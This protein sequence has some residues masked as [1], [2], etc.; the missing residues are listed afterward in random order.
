MEDIK[1]K[2]N[3]RTY[4]RIPFFL[5][6]PIVAIAIALC[7]Y[8]YSLVVPVAVAVLAYAFI[9]AGM[10]V[11]FNRRIVNS[12]IDTAFKLDISQKAYL[13]KMP[14]PYGVINKEGRILWGND[15]FTLMCRETEDVRKYI[16][17]IFP[18][19]KKNALKNIEGDKLECRT[20]WKDKIFD[21]LIVPLNKTDLSDSDEVW[22]GMVMFDIT[23]LEEYKKRLDDDKL[24][25]AN[26]YVDNYEET[27]ESVEAVKQSLLR[28]VIERKI[29]KY[30]TDVDA[31]IRRL[32]KDKYFLVFPKRHLSKLKEDK[33]SI[34][35]D[36]RSTKVGNE[37]DI[38]L[39]I[40]M[41]LG[42][43]SFSKSAEYSK[44]ATSL[45]L[46]RGGSQAVVKEGGD[47]SIY[48]ERGREVEM[49]TRVKAR[50][51]A[52][53]LKE[54][55]EN[56]ERV[57]VMGHK[58]S[59]FDCLGAAVG[60]YCAARNINKR[61]HILIDTV[62]ASLRPILETFTENEL[63]PEDMF[64]DSKKALALVDTK[65]L[66]I[67]VDTNKSEY[68]E[69]S[70]LLTK[71]KDVVVIDHHRVGMNVIE[72]PILSYIEPYA[73]STCELVAEIVQYFSED[74]S[75]TPAEADCIYAGML[76]DTNNFMSKTGVRTFEAA[77][78]LRRCGAEVTRV[79]KLLR[80]DINAYK[81][82]AEI[83]RN[84]EVYRNYF[85]ISECK[86]EDLESPT[87]VGAQASNELLNIV[88]IKAS[89]V[90]TSFEGLV[91]VSSRSIDE[92]DVQLIM[93]RIGGGG[94]LHTAGAQVENSDINEVKSRIHA[95]L[96]DMLESGEIK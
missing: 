37:S 71:T 4:L 45:A 11:V 55:M 53:A 20:T 66:V 28:A 31:V 73:S 64:I 3:I 25:V 52:Q 96:D 75:P 85:A 47:V 12:V 72:K 14:L 10:Y 19:I 63:Y 51:K 65:T 43:D 18:D 58:L 50:V 94:H 9:S 7:I 91:Y 57:I 74:I 44:I 41:G 6:I 24:V 23:S 56:R 90:L 1:I 48:G 16:S 21:V 33:F 60:I 84:A 30:F 2:S 46:G 35:E 29:H 86:A 93:E 42:A 70:E 79:R 89:F 69:C 83:V 34:L 36:I 40:G 77:A 15:E 39:S 49:N 76:I 32:E 62:T 80:E 13:E 95:I 59:D 22:Y 5:M 92:I 78:Y 27:I 8:D 26:V 54:L 88:G 61:C 68:T 38:T 67:V 81:A 17:N 82:R 87:I